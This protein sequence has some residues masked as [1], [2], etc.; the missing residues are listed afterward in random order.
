MKD[1]AER[2][3]WKKWWLGYTFGQI[4]KGK[5][6]TRRQG[7]SEQ[8]PGVRKAPWA[9]W[10]PKE[11]H[12]WVGAWLL[13]TGDMGGREMKLGRQAGWA[14]GR[15]SKVKLGFH[16]GWKRKGQDGYSRRPCW[17]RLESIWLVQWFK[18]DEEEEFIQMCAKFKVLF[19]L[20]G[21]PQGAS[22]QE[23]EPALQEGQL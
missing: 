9:S 10:K 6:H 12:Q 20:L 3:L 1:K 22:E 8:R 16:S 7:E 11:T 2:A 21:P 4:W 14:C 18:Q 23:L 13:S 19:W 15:G 17:G 5:G